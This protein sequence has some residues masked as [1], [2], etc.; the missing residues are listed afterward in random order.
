MEPT[1]ED[2]KR[3]CWLAWCNGSIGSGD[4]LEVDQIGFNEWWE[5]DAEFLL[6][7]L[8]IEPKPNYVLS[9]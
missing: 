6:T 2:W 3:L 7:V 5:D 9:S 1:K 4:L 8:P